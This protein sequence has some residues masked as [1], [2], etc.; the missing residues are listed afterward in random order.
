MFF[1][2]EVVFEDPAVSQFGLKNILSM[3]KSEGR[4]SSR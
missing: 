4:L 1:G 3:C 2:T